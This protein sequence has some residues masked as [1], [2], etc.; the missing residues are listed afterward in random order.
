MLGLTC[1]LICFAF[2]AVFVLFVFFLKVKSNQRRENLLRQETPCNLARLWGGQGI[3][4][5]E[6]EWNYTGREE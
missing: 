5:A 4:K 6:E 2:V 1:F 3:K